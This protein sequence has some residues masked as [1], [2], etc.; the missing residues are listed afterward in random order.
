MQNLFFPED[1]AIANVFRWLTIGGASSIRTL[2]NTA[3]DFDIDIG[4]ANK[5]L[6]ANFKLYTDGKKTIL[7]TLSYSIPDDLIDMIDLVS[8]TTYFGTP[9]SGVQASR[10]KP[11]PDFSN[12]PVPSC[13]SNVSV[14]G[15]PN[16]GGFG[17]P[18]LRM[19]Y[20][21][22]DFQANPTLGSTIG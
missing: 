8:P 15:F 17:R 2:D 12:Q 21:L 3:V 16:G 13:A 18:S 7:R 1:E 9:T 10:A 6:V 14:S 20:N 19:M 22:G 5:L 4:S 11:V